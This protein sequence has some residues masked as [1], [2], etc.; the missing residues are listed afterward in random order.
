MTNGHNTVIYTGMTSDLKSRV[1][2]HRNG[3]VNGFTR[4]YRRTKLVY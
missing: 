2:Q 3:V 4:R 1:W